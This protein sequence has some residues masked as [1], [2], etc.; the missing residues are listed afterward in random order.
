MTTHINDIPAS[1]NYFKTTIPCT[2]MWREYTVGSSGA[3][4]ASGGD[5]NLVATKESAAGQYSL[6]LPTG[7][8]YALSATWEGTSSATAV[9]S[10]ACL[11]ADPAAGTATMQFYEISGTPGAK[12]ATNLTSGEKFKI[13]AIVY[14]DLAP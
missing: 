7:A 11:V 6:V 3:I 4:T 1:I 13:H 10:C 9:S 8:E 12:V 2:Y 14:P 5:P